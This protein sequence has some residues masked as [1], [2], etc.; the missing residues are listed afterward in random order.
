MPFLVT[1]LLALQVAPVEPR[2]PQVPDTS[3]VVTDTTTRRRSSE[4][5]KPRRLPVTAEVLATAFRDAGARDMLLRAREARLRQD[6]ALLSY[7]ATAYQRLSAGVGLRAIGRDRLL[8]RTENASRVRWSRTSGAWVDL[9]GRRT[10]FPMLRDNEGE[11]DIDDISPIP[12]YPGREALWIGSGVA[13]AEVDDRELVH[14]IATGAEAYYRYSSG[15]SL[16]FRLSDGKVIRLR[17]LRIEPRRPEWRLSVGSFWFDAESGQLVRAAYRLAVPMDIWKVAEEES[18]SDGDDDDVPVAVK[19]LMTPMRANLESVTIEYGLYGGRFWLPRSQA[20]QGSAQVSFMRVPFKMEE[21]FKYASV[22]GTDSVPPIPPVPQSL[23]DSLFGDSLSWRD[24]TPEQRRE[25]REILSRADSARRVAR[26]LSRKAQ[27]DT[28]GMYTQTASRYE[29]GVRVAVRVP[30][31]STVLATSPELPASIY[32]PGEELFGSA[33]RDALLKTLDFS[34]QPDWA[35][36]KPELHYGIDLVRYNRVE[37]LSVGAGVR[38]AL[39]SGYHAELIPRLGLA[40]L[41]PNA[42]LFLARSNGRRQLQLGAYRRLEA[43]NDWGSPLSF[44]SSLSALLFG[45]DEGFYY[46]TVG[47]ELGATNLSGGGLSWRLFGEHHSDARSEASFSL[48]KA[49]NEVRFIRNI[50]ATNGDVAGAEAR[51]NRSLGL[52]PAGWRLLTDVRAEA[53]AGSF[54]YARL[55]F[56]ATVSRGL[57]RYLAAAVT[58]AAGTSSGNVPVQRLWYLGGSQT[59]RGQRATPD[60]AGAVGDAFWMARAELGSSFAGVRPVVFGDL[61]WAGSRRDWSEPGRPLS[62]VGVGA[63]FLDGLFRFDISRGLYPSERTRVDVY[64]EARF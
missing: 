60:G 46:R 1:L 31:D 56:D 39:G 11:V 50:D 16:T 22:N 55:A 7:D 54:D 24:L 30:C 34:L 21:S 36:Q 2:E 45:R 63:S 35:P 49:F 58:G 17:E 61:G 33:E 10:V 42:E 52:D 47:L 57:G 51:F 14:P 38:Q 40:D 4:S 6:S 15:D 23:R 3:R 53:A 62:G 37:G 32:E 20:A 64:L 9:K 59:V 19:A 8:F 48:A 43:A 27:C 12:Y 44:G 41:E 29:G 28:S 13:K 26:R 25:R 5:R 18:K